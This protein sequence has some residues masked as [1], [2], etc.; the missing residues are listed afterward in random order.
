[1]LAGLNFPFVVEEPDEL[2]DL[3][4][5]LAE[6]LAAATTDSGTGTGTVHVGPATSI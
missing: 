2:R 3:L 4:S 6:R 5:S 1:M